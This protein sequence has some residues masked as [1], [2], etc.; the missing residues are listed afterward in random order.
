MISF[1]Y[2][3]NVGAK[4]EEDTI[5]F[6][7]SEISLQLCALWPPKKSFRKCLA[8]LYQT[9]KS[10]FLWKTVRIKINHRGHL[11]FMLTFVHFHFHKDTTRFK[12]VRAACESIKIKKID[13]FE[14]KW[15]S[16]PTQRFDRKNTTENCVTRWFYGLK[17]I[18]GKVELRSSVRIMK[19][20]KNIKA[21]LSLNL[22]LYSAV[23]LL[24]CY[25][26]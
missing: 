11:K 23:E 20:N 15:L 26:R 5:V 21:I 7:T 1:T 22:K 10:L 3:S 12:A 19:I 13:L 24:K 9:Y 16:S 25:S 2:Q 4:N 17:T 18:R 8:Q 14:E 6:E